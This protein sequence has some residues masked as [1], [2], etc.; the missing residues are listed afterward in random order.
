MSLKKVGTC[1]GEK[2]PLFQIIAEVFP[3]KYM[4]DK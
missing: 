4:E 1:P 3:Q 2:Q